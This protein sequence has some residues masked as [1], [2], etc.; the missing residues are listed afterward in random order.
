MI[1]DG[2]Q[3][4]DGLKFISGS[5]SERIL[6]DSA[7]LVPKHTHAGTQAAIT[8]RPNTRH[9]NER[10]LQPLRHILAGGKLDP[11]NAFCV[12]SAPSDQHIFDHAIHK[13]WPMFSLS[14][15]PNELAVVKQNVM[16]YAIYNPVSY[17]ALLY[18]GACHMNFWQQS[19]T[20]SSER[21]P[22]LLQLKFKLSAPS[23]LLLKDLEPMSWKTL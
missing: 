19:I 7:K 23:G 16:S 18:A 4:N 2:Y 14:Q 5:D 21:N 17:Y 8:Q 1:C 3:D 13:Q 9:D 20:R 6:T 15:A 22:K 10:Q 11:F 12:E